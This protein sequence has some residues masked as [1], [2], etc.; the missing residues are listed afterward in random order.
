MAADGAGQSFQ[1]PRPPG[2]DRLAGETAAQVGG[3]VG[4]GGVTPARRLFKTFKTNC[5]QIA[6]HGGV[7]GARPWGFGFDHQPQRVYLGLPFEGR[8][9]GQ[10]FV[11]DGAESVNVGGGGDGVAVAGRLFRGHVGR[12]ADDGPGL[13]DGRQQDRGDVERFRRAGGVSPLMIRFVVAPCIRGLTPPARQGLLGEA[14]VGDVRLAAVV[15]EDVG[16]LEVAVEHAALVGVVNGVGHRRQQPRGVARRQGPRRLGETASLEEFHTQIGVAVTDADVV[17][18]H[19]VGVVEAGGGLGLG[20]EALEVF[21]RRQ[22]PGQ[23][24]FQGDDAVEALL[25]RLE[26]DA[27]AAAGDLFLD[28]VIAEVAEARQPDGRGRRGA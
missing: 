27:H 11:Q 5:F 28:L 1:P 18:G 4:G 23:Q 12:R 2:Q 19:D 13:G 8:P 6:V 22:R 9:A 26:N 7:E 15:Q 3:Q 10:Q 16:R 17:N 24:H 21:G 14:E 20:P 25:P